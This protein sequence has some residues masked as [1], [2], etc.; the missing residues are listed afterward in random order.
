MKNEEWLR[1]P[2]AEPSSLELCWGEASHRRSQWRMAARTEGFSRVFLW[3]AIASNRQQCFSNN[4]FLIIAVQ[5]HQTYEVYNV[6]LS[7]N[8][9]YESKLEATRPLHPPHCWVSHHRR[10]RRCHHPTLALFCLGQQLPWITSN[11]QKNIIAETLLSIAGNCWPQKNSR[12][13]HD[14]QP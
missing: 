8:I 11:Y 5:K 7:K 3:S 4:I 1:E 13:L 9:V 14:Y 6:H 12:K 2:K 10:R